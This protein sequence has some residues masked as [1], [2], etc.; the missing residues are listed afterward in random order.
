MNKI[1]LIS[2][3]ENNDYDTYDSAVVVA[4]DEETAKMINPSR[5]GR[6]FMTQEDWDRDYSSWCSSLDKV[7]VEYIGIA[8]EDQ[9][10]GVIC[11][12]FNAG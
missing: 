1:Y 7:E 9:K 2:Q 3:S 8:S 10:V 12:S 5:V 6:I 11:H 4:P